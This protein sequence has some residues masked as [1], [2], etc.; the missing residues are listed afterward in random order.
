MGGKLEAPLFYPL[1]R[2]RVK[3]RDECVQNAFRVIG[4]EL[5]FEFFARHLRGL[6]VNQV[7][8]HLVHFTVDKPPF[9]P[10]LV[11]P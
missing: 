5:G 6:L 10:C 2:F 4:G 8:W 9:A 11:T 3:G 7:L 1:W